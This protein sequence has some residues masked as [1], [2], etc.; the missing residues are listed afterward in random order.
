MIVKEFKHAVACTWAAACHF[1][2]LGWPRKKSEKLRRLMVSSALMP[3]K[4]KAR[5]LRTTW[6][7]SRW[8]SS[9]PTMVDSVEEYNNG[10]CL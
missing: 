10:I 3:W 1:T 7:S 9:R 4:R 8:A 6:R 2:E 5:L